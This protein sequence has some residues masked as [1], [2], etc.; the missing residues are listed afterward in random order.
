MCVY[1]M[2][3][4]CLYEYM[5]CVLYVCVYICHVCHGY[6]WRTEGS[7][8]SPLELELQT[9]VSCLTEVLGLN[10]DPLKKQQTLSTP[11]SLSSPLHL[12]SLRQA[13]SLKLE[14][15]HWALGFQVCTSTLA[16]YMG[17]GGHVCMHDNHSTNGVIFSVRLTDFSLSN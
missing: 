4:V 5:L 3:A 16:L 1:S 13:S 10:L 8:E 14:L 9:D 6:L 2:C 11:E 7:T 12:I 17:A 15:I